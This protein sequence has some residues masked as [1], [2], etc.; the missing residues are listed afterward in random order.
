L[1]ELY[2]QTANSIPFNAYSGAIPMVG[3]G[4][5]AYVLALLDRGGTS[6][7]NVDCAAASTVDGGAPLPDLSVGADL[8]TPAASPSGGCG[9][10]V[11]MRAPVSCW[12]MVSVLAFA[13]AAVAIVTRRRGRA[14]RGRGRAAD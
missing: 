4:A 13:S 7:E 3:F 1:P 14:S 2:N 12:W 9:C 10:D 5:A 11:G 8:A 6:T